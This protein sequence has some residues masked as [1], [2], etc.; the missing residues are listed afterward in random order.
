[1][2]TGKFGRI[3]LGLGIMAIALVDLV[4]DDFVFGQP[5]PKD[6]P[7]HAVLAYAAGIFMFASGAALVW[8][9]TAAAGAIAVLAYFGLVVCVLMFGRLVPAHYTE[10]G[11]YSN[12]AE[13]LALA[14]AALIAYAAT[15]GI[16]EAQAA[17]LM[18]VGRVAFGVCAI[19]F[20]GAHFVYMNLTAPLIPH[21]LPPSQVFWG[22]ATG[23]AHI[24]GG[25]ALITG[26]Q[27]RLAAIL[28]TV[29]YAAFT[30]LVHIPMLLSD[31]SRFWWERE[32]AEPGACRRGMGGDGFA[33]THPPRPYGG[34]AERE[35]GGGGESVPLRR[36][37]P[38][39]PVRTGED[40]L[41]KHRLAH[42]LADGV[43]HDEIGVVV[44]LRGFAVDDDELGAVALGEKRKARRGIDHQ[45]RAEHPE[46]DRRP[47]SPVPRAPSRAPASPGRRR[48]SRS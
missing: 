20:G 27:A 38:P 48:S 17:R 28:T 16:G 32:R 42:R 12:I 14:A 22:Y 40:R 10:Y 18:R 46:T 15:G 5:V 34:G 19:L 1:M 6:F 24:A 8:R 45:R 33:G 21:W 3:V 44:L 35:R 29:M 37:A 41:D 31:P 25:I 13:Q 43:A 9:R 47:A 2:I 26:I 30:P 36:F 23:V 11:L 39:S 4:W 7:A